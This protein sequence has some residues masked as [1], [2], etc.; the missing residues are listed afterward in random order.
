VTHQDGNSSG[1]NSYT[2]SGSFGAQYG[3]GDRFHVF[4]ELG[5]SYGWANNDI[6][7][8]TSLGSTTTTTS[9]SH[10]FGTRSVGGIAFNF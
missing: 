9:K 1:A 4:G 5:L 10:A 8:S 3:L 2:A 6:S 7:S